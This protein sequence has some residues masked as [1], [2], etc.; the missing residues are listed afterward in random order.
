MAF[1]NL[2][3]WANRL[4]GRIILHSLLPIGLFLVLLFVVFLP[5]L[6]STAMAAKKAGVRNVVELAMGIME[7]QE[8]EVRAGRRTRAYAETRAKELIASLRFDEK[9][10]I[11]IQSEGPRIIHHPTAA[12]VGQ[13]TDSL[14]PR[15]AKLFRDLDQAA[16]SMEG[17]FLEYQWARPGESALAPKVSYVKRFGPWGWILG[18][19]VYL[20][21][22]Q[23]D[24]RGTFLWMFASTL[25]LAAG[26]FFLSMKF[27]A[28][29]IK[30]VNG[31]VEGLRTSDLSRELEID[32]EDEIGEAARAFNAYNAGL[33]TTVLDVKQMAE[34]VAS[35]STELAATAQQ[36]VRTV[37]EIATVGDAL[38]ASGKQVVQAMKA[39]SRHVAEA[40]AQTHQVGER[41]SEAVV[42]TERGTK[43]GEAAAEGMENI[44][45]VTGNIF[46]AVQVIQEIANQTNLLSLN[47]AIEA[48]KAGEQGKGFSVVA[49]EVRKLSERSA[50]AARDIEHLISQAQ[51]T[52]SLGTARVVETLHN[53]EA[54]RTQI[55]AIASNIRE[56]DK[57][58]ELEAQTGANVE[59]LMDRTSQELDHNAVA[60]Q[61][62]A[63]T[64]REITST[65]EELARV[66]DGLREVVRGFRL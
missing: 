48:A 63:A 52:V 37:E 3:R 57:L 29:I 10:Y 56:V 26:I 32:T 38:K 27:A 36:M 14:D 35:G 9:N 54:I 20:D 2:K 66:A 5:R 42:D 28:R 51:G 55:G 65:S 16:L 12:L 61:Q 46:E 18:A 19:G 15:M 17:G 1:E 30:P 21:D 62:L 25:L 39:L 58:D 50:A 13:L 11:W 24:V 40:T 49:D 41:S 64:V 31:L 23:R 33:R 43:A 53:L 7:N 59:S 4:S 44:Q 60:T 22:V 34:R 47:A 6:E 45:K 8:I